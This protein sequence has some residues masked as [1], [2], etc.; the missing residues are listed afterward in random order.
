M[1]PTFSIIIPTLNEKAYLPR[2]L[3]D[4][5]SQTF[6]HFEVIVV[7]GISEDGT[8]EK[9][10]SFIPV[11]TRRGIRLTVLNSPKRN[12]SVQRNMSAKKAR[13]TY[14][15]FFDADVQ[16]PAN[17][18]ADVYKKLTENDIA[19]ATTWVDADSHNPQDVA[20]AQLNNFVMEVSVLIEKDFAV[21]FNC[22]VTKVL[23][24]KVGGFSEEVVIAEDQHF[25]EKVRRAGHKL[26]ILK[27]PRIIFSLRRFRHEG[28]LSALRKYAQTTLH[29]LF[30]GP[31]TS[32]LFE[33][34]MA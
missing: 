27:S 5:S 21:G 24:E 18:L 19:L 26:T 8:R 10:E 22:I 20:I 13:G 2:L 9:A 29:I 25:S 4:V 1:K 3:E 28:R 12:V 14:L 17:Y 32:K 34:D 23:F 6:T 15:F 7:D 31:V 16:I 30:K 11:F 33:H